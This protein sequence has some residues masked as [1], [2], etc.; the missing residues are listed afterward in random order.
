[1]LCRWTAVG[2]LGLAGLGT[3]S[4]LQSSHLDEVST[5]SM[6]PVAAAPSACAMRAAVVACL[7][8]IAG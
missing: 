5:G 1:M 7:R 4:S 3:P 8:G 6:F 2:R